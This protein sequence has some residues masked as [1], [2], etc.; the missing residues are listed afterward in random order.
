LFQPL[1]PVRAVFF[2][3]GHTLF[4]T[5]SSIELVV[6]E[7]A[8][9]GRPIAADLAERLWTDA[10]SRSRLPEEMAKGR[11][12]GPAQHRACWLELWSE[13]E[14]RSPGLGERLYEFETSAAGWEPYVDARAVLD[15]LAARRVRM[16]VISDT[17]CDLRPLFEHHDLARYFATF[18]MSYQHGVTKPAPV[19]FSAA[20]EGCGVEPSEALMVG[21]NHR[22]DGGAIDAGVRTLLLPLVPTGTSRG[23][24]AV[25]GV[26]D[27]SA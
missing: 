26:L 6:R 15:E 13:L 3:F 24:A 18:V 10:R 14:A 7:S 22:N 25:L 2:D 16:A 23:L 4:D 9:L 21:D 19:L 20:C 1:R 12:L 27:A 17:G 11:D 5:A 8:A